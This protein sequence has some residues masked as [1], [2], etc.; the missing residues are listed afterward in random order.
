MV[1]A[2]MLGLDAQLGDA[3]TLALMTTTN[4]WVSAGELRQTTA[5]F[6]ARVRKEVAPG[7]Q[8]AWLREWTTGLKARDG[9]RRTH[10]HWPC[11]GVDR[12][13]SGALSAIASEV[14]GRRAGGYVAGVKP[15]W[16]ATGL[17]RYVA[18]L[19]GH[20][21][22][23]A[24]GPPDGWKGRRYGTSR[25]YYSAAASE[26]RARAEAIVRDDRLV[27]LLEREL[28]D[29]FGGPDAIEGPWAD[30]WNEQ[31]EHRYVAAIRRPPPRVVEV[32]L[33]FWERAA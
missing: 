14:W 33:D 6:V 4:R 28:A 29:E 21:L 7:F 24:Q 27:A 22:K 31:L 25:G 30:L 19:V 23:A 18:G 17:G 5:Q 15:V 9:R 16:D 2:A 3:P 10:Y 8:Y 26:L 1:T 11:K 32:P 12:D 13:A 20:H